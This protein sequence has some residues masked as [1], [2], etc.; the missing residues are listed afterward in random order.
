MA[1]EMVVENLTVQ[2]E[3]K[4][5]LQ[6]MGVAAAAIESWILGKKKEYAGK[7]GVVVDDIRHVTWYEKELDLR[8]LWLV[9]PLP[10]LPIGKS[11]D[12]EGKRIGI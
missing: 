3:R 7:E 12:G 5:H 6:A 2:G 1:S 8:H 4:I 9:W 10:A 11:A